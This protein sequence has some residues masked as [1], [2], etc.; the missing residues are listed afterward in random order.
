MAHPAALAY[1]GRGAFGA[2]Q[3]SAPSAPIGD[4]SSAS[5]GANVTLPGFDVSG[6]ISAGFIGIIVLGLGAFY[7][8]TRG[9]QL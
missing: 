7:I 6:R 5:V 9:M 3:S 2:D 1:I 4:V 8:I